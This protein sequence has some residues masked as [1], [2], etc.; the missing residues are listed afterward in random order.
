MGEVYLAED[1]QLQRKAALKFLA[2]EFSSNSDHLERF[3]REARAASA[4]NHPNICTIYEINSGGESPFI[5][6]E[7]IEGETVSA[8]IRRRRR[9]VRQTVDVA[10]QVCEA[11]AEAHE[12]G[13]V[14]RDIKPANIIVTGR[15]QAKILDFGL[16]KLL[17]SES[18]ATTGSQQFLTKAGMIVGTASYMSPEQARGLNVDGRTDVWSLGVV[19]YEML[20]GSLPFTG[21]TSTDTLAAILT[22]TPIPPS[23]LFREIPSELERIVLKALHANRDERYRS[24]RAMVQD[25]RALVRKLEAESEAQVA[26]G[27]RSKEEDTFIFDTA[28]TEVVA[29]K[30]TAHELVS[31]SRRTS[32]LRRN[33]AP[34]I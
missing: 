30:V 23:R 6:M 20:T 24:A 21:E 9:N 12:A 14:H 5:A 18:F 10:I 11:L 31:S 4:L 28:P 32:N 34:I 22:K 25:L 8:M 2:A 26:A 1:D 29:R 13:I 7:F 15:G 16:V 27:S 19:L 17:E 3:L 33:L